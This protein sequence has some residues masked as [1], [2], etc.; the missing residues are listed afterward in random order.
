MIRSHQEYETRKALVAGMEQAV[1][2][3]DTELADQHPLLAEA[4][5]GG[6]RSLLD[7][8]RAEVAEYEALRDGRLVRLSLTALPELGALLHRARLAAGLTQEMLAARA[9]LYPDQL[10]G[11][12]TTAYHDASLA[13]CQAVIAALGVTLHIDALI[14]TS[15]VDAPSGSALSTPTT[16]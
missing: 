1:A 8:A 12:E 15:A 10:A 4:M 2:R 13:D 3:A 11:Y 16:T 5:R 6:Q 14:A 7:E 9:G